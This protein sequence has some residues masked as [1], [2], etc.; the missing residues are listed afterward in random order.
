M[1]RVRLARCRGYVNKGGIMKKRKILSA[2]SRKKEARFWEMMRAAGR[3][4]T[5]RK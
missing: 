3:G 1:P 2:E 4:L 5:C